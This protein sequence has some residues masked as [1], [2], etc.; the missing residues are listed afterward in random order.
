[1]GQIYPASSLLEADEHLLIYFLYRDDTHYESGEDEKRAVY[2]AL[3]RKDGFASLQARD[4][5]TGEWLTPVLTVPETATGLQINAKVEGELRVE[6]LD[7]SSG[8]PIEG[9]TAE[10]CVPIHGDHTGVL[11]GWESGQVR[12]IANRDVQLRFHL[13][14]GQIFSFSWAGK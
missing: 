1:V 12:E 4:G 11:A 7:A 13:G 9:F 14:E 5:R 10:E 8:E 2:V 3:M 6:V